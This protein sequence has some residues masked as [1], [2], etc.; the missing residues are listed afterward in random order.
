MTSSYVLNLVVMGPGV[1]NN[2]PCLYLSFHT[3]H[4]LT[5][6]W[7]ISDLQSQMQLHVLP[8]EWL[9]CCLLDK[10]VHGHKWLQRY[11]WDTVGSTKQWAKADT[12]AG[13]RPCG[14]RC[15][16]TE[17]LSFTVRISQKAF[18]SKFTQWAWGIPFPP[19]ANQAT[20][21]G[22]PQLPVHTSST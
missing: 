1:N 11:L 12:E 5:T 6:H 9:C 4:E 19:C 14:W 2:I 8:T 21:S 17:T 3:N 7:D 20:N 22:F 18:R 15:H 16:G 10:A 13:W